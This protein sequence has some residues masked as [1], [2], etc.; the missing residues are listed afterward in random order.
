MKIL[1]VTGIYPPDIGGPATHLAQCVPFFKAQGADVS[2]VTFG[3]STE[4][5]IDASGIEV[6]E[7]GRKRNIF[8]R[9]AQFLRAVSHA[10]R[11]A[12]VMYV[13]DMSLAGLAAYIVARRRSIPYVLRLG[14]DFVWEQAFERGAT[15][16][17]Y[18]SFQGREPFPYSLRRRLASRI[19]RSAQT[20]IVPS[21]F[22][23]GI[24]KGWGVQ[25][26]KIHVVPNAIDE[27]Q[28]AATVHTHPLVRRVMEWRQ[29]GKGVVVSSGRFVRWKHFDVLARAARDISDAHIVI[30]GS[31]PEE[32]HIRTVAGENVEIVPS[33]SRGEL[34]ALFKEADCFMLLSQGETF[35]FASLEAFLSGLPV[36][37]VKEPALEEV[38]GSY[39]GAGV[40]FLP[41]REYRTVTAALRNLSRFT[42]PSEG[43]KE[44]LRTRYSLDG[45]LEA[46]WGI[47][48]AYKRSHGE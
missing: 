19:A 44:V 47:I 36:I 9:F 39:E 8:F 6:S 25:K 28:F 32:D 33:L 34:S 45:H 5:R 16:L 21:M 22:L 29:D 46:I 38:F 24:V 4:H 2:V 12:S 30:V 1:I 18:Q 20:V 41:D 10:S 43:D 11:G 42:P 14:G 27:R 23:A 17:D 3:T 31:G 40:H 15:S 7:V 13:H 37:L 48:G 26:K 35:S